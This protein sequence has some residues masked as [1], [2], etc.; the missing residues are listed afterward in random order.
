E[1]K[2][3]EFVTTGV[4]AEEREH[5][6]HLP[7]GKGIL[8]LLITEARPMR[9]PDIS[10]DTRSVGFPANH[11]EMHS[12]LGAPVK[13]GGKVFGNIYLTEKEDEPEFT[14]EDE[15]AIVVLAV[16]AGVAIENARARSELERLALMEDRERIAKELH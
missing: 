15:K 12:F 11:P 2:I 3:L 4:T 6:G 13:A 10:A 9:L 7:I 16:Q 5:I 1:G 14:N 8:G